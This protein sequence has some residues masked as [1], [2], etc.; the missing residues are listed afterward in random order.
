VR[1][2]PYTLYRTSRV[3]PAARFA[4]VGS[5]VALA[6]GPVAVTTLALAGGEAAP[7]ATRPQPVAPRP[8]R[9]ALPVVAIAAVGDVA[10][11]HAGARPADPDAIFAHVRPLLRGDLVT[12]NLETA[13]TDRAAAKCGDGRDG[14]YAFR[15]PPSSARTLRRAGFTLVNLANNHTRDAGD[16]GL[17]DTA[18][19]LR[20]ARVAHTGA[21]GQVAVLRAGRVRVAVVGFAP[22]PWAADLL[23][24]A[25]ARRLIRAAARR[26]DVVVVQMH[27]GAEGTG[28]RH[29]AGAETYLGEPRG[30]PVAFAHA[31]VDAGADLVV[32]HGPHLVRALEWY[33]GRL[34][35]YSLGNFA[36]YRNFALDGPLGESAVL[37]VRLR[38]DGTFVSG[39]LVPVR[40]EGTGTPVPD[41][42]RRALD[43]MRALSRAD[44]GAAAPSLAAD[45]N[46]SA[47][48]PAA[49]SSR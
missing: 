45:G 7:A 33:R 43:A 15:A 24:L 9:A 32:G 41:R 25:A 11:G 14:C 39:R 17:A 1:A 16:A 29:L 34:I 37:R 23:D 40:L 35:A 5:V 44:L 28:H 26:A 18:A 4:A 20:A 10:L 22:Y 21:P 8:A 12:A 27:A 48:R 19:A 6:L 30:D 3:S 49:S 47:R 31:A 36:A 42:G 2:K 13:L 46:L 38:A